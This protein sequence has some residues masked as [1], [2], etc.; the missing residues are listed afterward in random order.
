MNRL[1]RVVLTFAGLTACGAAPVVMPTPEVV[2][3]EVVRPAPPQPAPE[4]GRARR[5]ATQR[6]FLQAEALRRAPQLMKLAEWQAAGEKPAA[7]VAEVAAV[8]AQLPMLTT[9]LA[10]CREADPAVLDPY[11][12]AALDVPCNLAVRGRDIVEEQYLLAAKREARFP[13]NL[14]DAA[15]RYQRQGRV[16]WQ[17]LRI[18]QRLESDMAERVAWLQPYARQVGLPVLGELFHEGFAARRELRKAIRAGRSTWPLPGDVTDTSFVQ[19]ITPRVA[20]LGNDGPMPGQ[21]GQLLQVRPIDGHWSVRTLDGHAVRRE[22]RLAAVWRPA[23][24]AC[25]V[26]WLQA[27]QTPN[28]RAWQAPTLWLEDDLRLVRCPR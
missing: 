6:E 7:L 5:Q 8:A 28:G 10:A 19:E 20:A 11:D 17:T 23:K 14:R 1:L 12:D 13:E 26:T 21:R 27:T 16:A 4:D 15:R 25:I 22:R 24:G 3:P 2:Q 18:F 9:L